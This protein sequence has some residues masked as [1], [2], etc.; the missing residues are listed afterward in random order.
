MKINEIIAEARANTAGVRAG[1]S[2]RKN[3]QPLSAEEQAAKDKAKSDKWLEKERA[4]MAAKKGVTEGTSKELRL[5]VYQVILDIHFGAKYGDEMI[6]TVTDELG[7]YFDDVQASGDPILQKVY[8]YVRQE[9]AEAEGDPA[10]MDRVALNAIEFLNYN[11]ARGSLSE[12]TSSGS[13]GTA[14]TGGKSP[15]VGTLF[16]GNYKPK[17]PFTAKKKV[18]KK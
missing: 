10:R 6:D 13:I 4:K 16:G 11:G 5:A 15:N 1:L 9:G 17:T 2:K 18:G 7:D 12:T 14:M 3:A 8:A